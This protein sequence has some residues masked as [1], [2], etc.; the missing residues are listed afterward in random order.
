MQNYRFKLRCLI[1]KWTRSFQRFFLLPSL[2]SFL[3][4]VTLH[5]LWNTTD[6]YLGC[7]CGECHYFSNVCAACIWPSILI[8][9]R[10]ISC[11]TVITVIVETVTQR[12]RRS[13]CTIIY[14]VYKKLDAR[15]YMKS[16]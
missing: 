9:V 5:L 16:A 3:C 2:F 8:W 13:M 15:G 11:L 14:F 10:V 7:S 1:C 12:H 4:W 6:E